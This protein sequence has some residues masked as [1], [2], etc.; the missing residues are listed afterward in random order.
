MAVVFGFVISR[1]AMH[2]LPLVGMALL[3]AGIAGVQLALPANLPLALLGS[4]LT[5]LAL[6]AT[7]APALFVAGFSLQ[8]QQPAAGVR[9]HRTAAGGRGVHGRADLRPLRATRYPATSRRHRR[10]A[11]G[12]VRA[13]HRR[14]GVRR[15]GLRAE[16]ARPQTPD[17][18]EFLDGDSPAWYSPPLLA[19]LRSRPD[20]TG[21]GRRRQP[22]AATPHRHPVTVARA[23]AVRLRRIGTGGPRDNAGRCQLPPAACAS[24]SASGSP[25]TS[26]SRRPDGQHFDA[27][28]ASEV[29]LAAERTAAHGASLRRR[30]RIP[31]VQRGDRGIADV[32]GHRR[33]RRRARR[34]PDRARPAPPQRTARSPTGQC[35]RGRRGAHRHSGSAHPPARQSADPTPWRFDRN[36]YNDNNS[37]RKPPHHGG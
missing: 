24:W 19:R 26:A 2:Y 29:R 23:R 15:R 14:R 31:L 1:R 21:S 34:Q 11:L 16:R 3:A 10:R 12:R 22:R 17:L 6:G 25:S 35:R 37:G 13:R 20:V 33:G 8:S 5:G 4:A 9:D 36:A 28:R 7:V 32:E 18:D 27:D 30:G